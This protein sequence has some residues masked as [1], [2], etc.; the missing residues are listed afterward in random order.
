MLA[1][2]RGWHSPTSWDLAGA[3]I[4]AVGMAVIMLGPRAT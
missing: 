4:A 2:G 1:L 3:A